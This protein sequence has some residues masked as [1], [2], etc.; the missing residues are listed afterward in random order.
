MLSCVD[1]SWKIDDHLK[2]KELNEPTKKEHPWHLVKLSDAMSD[3]LTI[4]Q[5]FFQ[6][7]DVKLP[8]KNLLRINQAIM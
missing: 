1:S 6:D 4:E 5:A 2:E 8:L 3:E 7:V